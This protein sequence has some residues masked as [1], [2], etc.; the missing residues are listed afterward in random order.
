MGRTVNPLL[1]SFEGSNPSLPTDYLLIAGLDD[2]L[3]ENGL[4]YS[5]TIHSP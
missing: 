2:F 3:I 1:Y 4:R 5:I